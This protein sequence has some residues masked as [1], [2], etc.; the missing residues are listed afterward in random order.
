MRRLVA[1]AALLLVAG[2]GGEATPP[3][4]P[5]FDS[6]VALGDSY[7]A[8]PGIPPLRHAA[9]GR[10]AQNY[11]QL[12]AEA[13]DA[14]RVVD[15]SCSASLASHLI[16]AQ[17]TPHATVEPPQGSHL[18]K[19]TDLV[20]VGWGLNHQLLSFNVLVACLPHVGQ[21]SGCQEFLAQSPEQLRARA[22][23][24]GV[25][26]RAA[27]EAIRGRSP[28]AEIVLVG[29]PSLGDQ[30]CADWPVPEQFPAQAD[31][32]MAALD[33][34]YE[35]LAADL[36][37]HYADVYAAS[38]GHGVCAEHAW[39]SGY[40]GDPARAL[41]LHPVDAYHAAVAKLVAKTLDD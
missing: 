41:W 21:P 40:P 13:L 19:G 18:R 6:Y 33:E 26:V 1:L 2:C 8:G 37:V 14:E 30:A 23:E 32:V 12:L 31:V 9:C 20:T 34:E 7:T 10:S 36:E 24:V 28:D 38:E 27:L 3:P 16:R 35:A 15:A 5:G 25:E 11:P 4:R 17:R 39:V 29:Y 22:H